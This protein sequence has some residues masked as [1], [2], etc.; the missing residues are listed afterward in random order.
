[1]F[2]TKTPAI[3]RARDLSARQHTELVIHNKNGKI[4]GK[5]SHGNKRVCLLKAA[6]CFSMKGVPQGSSRLPITL[7]VAIGR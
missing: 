6:H 3:D 2:S 5:D 4:S 7:R 1:V